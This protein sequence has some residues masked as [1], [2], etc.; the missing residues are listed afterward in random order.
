MRHEAGRLVLPRLQRP[1]VCAEHAVQ[2]ESYAHRMFMVF[3][4]ALQCGLKGDAS[5]L[6][7]APGF[8]RM[9]WIEVTS[10]SGASESSIQHPRSS[11]NKHA[12]S[13]AHRSELSTP[14]KGG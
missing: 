10:S 1:A 4:Y 2:A 6:S 14:R 7:L 8:S 13:R 12:A 5:Q 9:V 3:M 11:A